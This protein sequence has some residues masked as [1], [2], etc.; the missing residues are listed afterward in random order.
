MLSSRWIGWKG[1]GRALAL[2]PPVLGFLSVG[3]WCRTIT[4]GYGT[5]G[6]IRVKG[7]EICGY[8]IPRRWE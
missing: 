3:K 8:V 7:G 6:I 4:D 5:A 2:H 1:M